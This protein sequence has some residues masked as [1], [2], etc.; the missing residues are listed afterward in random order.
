MLISKAAIYIELIHSQVRMRVEVF[1]EL[2]NSLL[3]VGYRKRQ[4]IL[5][6]DMEFVRIRGGGGPLLAS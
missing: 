6:E 4:V 1:G 3:R 2:V 5:V